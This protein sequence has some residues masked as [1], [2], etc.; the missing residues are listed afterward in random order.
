M[1]LNR[2]GKRIQLPPLTL[3]NIIIKESD[4]ITILGLTITRNLSNVLKVI[5][6]AQK[7]IFVLRK[8]KDILDRSTLNTPYKT[9]VRPIIEFG[10]V[11]YDNCTLSIGQ[12]IE[13][14]Q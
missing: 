11:I 12:S 3:N 14:I 4:A 6:K 1:I 9:M 5:Q 2:K 8:Y 7:R 13:A 10:N